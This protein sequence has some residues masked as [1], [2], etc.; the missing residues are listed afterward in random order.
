MPRISINHATTQS[1][2]ETFIRIR[3]F[4]QNDKDIK[5]IDSKLEITFDESKKTGKAN[6][7]QFKASFEVKPAAEGSSI[8]LVV[9]LPLLLT[10]F[11]GKVEETVKAK[12]AKYLA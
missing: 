12:L 9:D 7:S 6:G 5:K 2:D 4:F 1:A 3:D 10:P 11:K 8:T